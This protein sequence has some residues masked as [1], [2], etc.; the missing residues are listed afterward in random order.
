MRVSFSGAQCTGKS[1]LLQRCKDIYK[2]YTFVDEVTR[3]VRREYKVDINELGG[4]ETQLYIL[5]EH[6]KNHFLHKDNIIMDRCILDG[7]VYT[8]YL[9]EESKVSSSILAAFN[10]LF[11]VLYSRLDYV[12][13]TDPSDVKLVDDGERSVDIKFRERIISIFDDVVNYKLS[14]DNRKKIIKLSGTVEERLKTIQ[15]ILK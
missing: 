10:S 11:N 13:Y 8:R 14:D 15:N 4:N 7:Y 6:I 1:T 2:D 5:S 3:L 12:F 9:V